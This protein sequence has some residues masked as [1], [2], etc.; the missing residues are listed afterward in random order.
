MY[1]GTAYFYILQTS[2]VNFFLSGKETPC[3]IDSAETN[4]QATYVYFFV[5]H[6][7]IF[8]TMS[9][10]GISVK[11]ASHRKQW[12]KIWTNSYFQVASYRPPSSEFS[13]AN[14]MLHTDDIVHPRSKY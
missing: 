10:H 5:S 1:I 3:E 9:A 13:M 14:C 8:I 11:H 12:L 2:H 4:L 6:P 7:A